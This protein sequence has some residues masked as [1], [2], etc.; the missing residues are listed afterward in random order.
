V[1]R[2]RSA[3]IRSIVLAMVLTLAA[4]AV[5]QIST[6]RNARR[7]EEI[8]NRDAH[9]R[10]VL[11]ALAAL[12]S[13]VQDAVIGRNGYLLTGEPRD[14]QSY[15][16][17]AARIPELL[18]QAQALTADDPAQAE[19]ARRLLPLVEQELDDLKVGPHTLRQQGP[20]ALA[21]VGAEP[22]PRPREQIRRI[23]DQLADQE[24][25]IRAACLAQTHA[26]ASA[27]AR[28]LIV[29]SVY[30]V[31]VLLAG[32]TLILRQQ[33]R[34]RRT[35][36]LCRQSEEFFRN[37]FDHAATG[38]ALADEDG[39]WLKTNRALCELVGY[40]EEE[41]LRIAPRQLTEA[42]DLE[43][44]QAAVEEL[45]AGRVDRHQLEMR[46][47]HKDGHTV[48]ALVTKSLVRDEQ[49]RPQ[50]LIS[51]IQDITE[52]KRAEDGLRHQLL[53]DPLTG[54]PNRLLLDERLRRGIE[55]AN[56]DP[57]FRLALLFLD[58]DRFKLINDSL[59]HAAGDMLLIT[60]AERLRQCV[61]GGDAV[62]GNASAVA[63]AGAGGRGTV[64]RL[65]G[66]EFT[67]LLEGLRAPGDAE[68]VA[69]RILRELARPVEFARQQIRAAASIGIVHA[70]GQRYT[71]AAQLLADADAA[72]YEAKAAGRGRYA[73]FDAE[74]RHSAP[75]RL[76]LTGEPRLAIDHGQLMLHY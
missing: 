72:L 19:R 29:A 4:S 21:S 24:Q 41:L 55:R 61:R 27:Q 9:V 10:E 11:L 71:A 45:R 68:R 51:Q 38:M 48:W 36:R 52:R 20:A 32:C 7:M 26:A 33:T 34:Q 59:G 43:K 30:R 25:Q 73:V 67:V 44:E 75:E 46:Y 31:F 5:F 23:I 17:A 60:V 70:D 40:S 47:L 50:T 57:D 69:E 54:L 15:R 1:Q 62:G 56:Q 12:R 66:D 16:D 53:H 6:Y 8:G 64:A 14:L 74:A 2:I 13:A 28:S 63:A 35:E 42:E 18:G 76:Q 49:G 39:R 3:K 65:G 58:L 22:D 37:A